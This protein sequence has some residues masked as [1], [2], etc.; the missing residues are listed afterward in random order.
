MTFKLLKLTIK[1]TKAFWR[2]QFFTK[3]YKI[4]HTLISGILHHFKTVRY[5][6]VGLSRCL[7]ICCWCCYCCTS[8]SLFLYC[9]LFSFL[10]LL[11]LLLLLLQNVFQR[12]VLTPNSS[13]WFVCVRVC[14]WEGERGRER[15]E[16]YSLIK[17]W[18][19]I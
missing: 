2:K 10:L 17:N 4:S 18:L 11:L 3:I 1:L 19:M 8:L 12:R 7:S 6:V 16:N 15:D 9:V 5:L 13:G 14:V